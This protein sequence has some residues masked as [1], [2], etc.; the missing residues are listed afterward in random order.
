MISNEAAGISAVASFCFS[1]KNK[2][3]KK[4]GESGAKAAR[5][6]KRKNKKSGKKNIAKRIPRTASRARDVPRLRKAA[7]Q[8]ETSPSSVKPFAE[9]SAQADADTA[10]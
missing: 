8:K 6:M 3:M 9:H 1:P 2:G 7:P 10:S 5:N 4:R